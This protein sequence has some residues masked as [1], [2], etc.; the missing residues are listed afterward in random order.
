MEIAKQRKAEI[1]PREIRLWVEA[2]NTSD[3]S[4][5]RAAIRQTIFKTIEPD[6]ATLDQAVAQGDLKQMCARK[7]SW[8]SHAYELAGAP[9]R[10]SKIRNLALNQYPDDLV[11]NFEYAM[12][13][14]QRN[15]LDEA[16]RFLMRCTS[17]RPMNPEIWRQLANS[18]HEIGESEQAINTIQVAIELAPNEPAPLLRLSQW[19]L[20]DLQYDQAIASAE[21]AYALDNNLHQCWKIIGQAHLGNQRFA[22]ALGAFEHFQSKAAGDEHESV[23]QWITRCREGL[24]TKVRRELKE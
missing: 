2:M 7:L 3:P 6:I 19:F 4:R 8:L 11:L 9:D 14:R 17:I 20:Q 18:F 23:N 5:L 15:Q 1:Q 21:R 22:E 13:L 24:R 12:F 16:I 10:S